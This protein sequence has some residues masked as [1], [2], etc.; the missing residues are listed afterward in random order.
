VLFF[1]FCVF[2]RR[3][4]A[5]RKKTLHSAQTLLNGL[6]GLNYLGRNLKR[7]LRSFNFIAVTNKKQND[8]T[9]RNRQNNGIA[10]KQKNKQKGSKN[11][12]KVVSLGLVSEFS[13]F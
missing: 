1:W 9:A 10:K 13:C 3:V 8:E 4:C 11:G 7:C 6:A 2:Q 12:T 5:A